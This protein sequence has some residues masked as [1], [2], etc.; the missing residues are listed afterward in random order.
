M[1]AT[2]GNLARRPRLNRPG[3]HVPWP[4][5]VPTDQRHTGIS[6]SNAGLTG[7]SYAPVER[8]WAEMIDRAHLLVSARSGAECGFYR[9][10]ERCGHGGCGCSLEVKTTE[11]CRNNL[12]GPVRFDERRVETGHGE[13]IEAPAT[14]RAGNS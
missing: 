1:V 13:A 8:A 9:E 12:I 7:S 4:Y 11:R 3:C 10:G 2:P 5:L 6:A 14:A